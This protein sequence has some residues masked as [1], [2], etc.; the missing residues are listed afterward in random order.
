LNTHHPV[1]ESLLHDLTN[2][3]STLVLYRRDK[4]ADL[5]NSVSVC[6]DQIISS[7]AYGLRTLALELYQ[8]MMVGIAWLQDG[9]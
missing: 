1:A 5:G 7:Y 6:F 2:R 3:P 4:L 9:V 8:P